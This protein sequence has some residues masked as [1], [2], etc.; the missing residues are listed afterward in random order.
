MLK[1]VVRQFAGEKRKKSAHLDGID[2]RSNFQRGGRSLY[3]P[4]LAYKEGFPQPLR[5]DFSRSWPVWRQWAP[6]TY[7]TTL[8]ES[9]ELGERDININDIVDVALDEAAEVSLPPL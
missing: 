5:R 6:S 7:W 2:W 9:D 8:V 4:L 3:M 1:R